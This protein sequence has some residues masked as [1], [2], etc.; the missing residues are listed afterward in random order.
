MVNET[1]KIKDKHRVL[2]KIIKISIIIFSVL[3]LLLIIFAAG[4]LFKKPTYVEVVLENP[5]KGI[6]EANTNLNG[7]IDTSAVIEQAIIEFNEDYI[8]YLL[9]ALG[10]G[11][12]HNSIIGG[13]PFL[14]LVMTDDLGNEIWYSEIIEGIPNSF[15]GEIENEDL[16][17]TISKETAVRAILS[18]D[19]SQFMKDSSSKGEIGIEMIANKA[20]LFAKGYLDMYNELTGEEISVE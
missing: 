11:Y 12:L 7:T 19:V 5:L 8:N 1:V 2:K 15:L 3:L 16:R 18:E 13:N 17:I 20:E 9:V 4:Y 6:V 14:E 10:T